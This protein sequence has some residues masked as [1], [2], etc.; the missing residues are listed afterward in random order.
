MGGFKIV[1]QYSN[2]L[3]RKGHHVSVVHPRQLKHM[4]VERTS[5]KGRIKKSAEFLRSLMG[6]PTID[7]QSLD[8]RVSLIFTSS[9]DARHIP[10]G[11][12]IFATGW[13]T[14]AS[15]L[16]C[17]PN[18]GERFYLIQH[19]ETFQADETTIYDTW[20]APLHKVVI[21]KWLLELGARLGCADIEYIPNAINPADYPMLNSVDNRTNS[22]AMMYSPVPF[23]GA[24]DGFQA[25][26]IV[27]QSVPD[28]QVVLFGTSRPSN[29][30]PAWARY[31]RTPPQDFIVK[32]IY[33]R[34]AVF[35]SPS[36][37]EGFALPP[38]EA[39]CCGCALA[40]TDSQGTREYVEPE[41]TGLL[42]APEDPQ[43][44]ADNIIRL[45]KNKDLR[46]KLV[47]AAR[48]KIA[49]I[50]WTE[51]ADKLERFITEHLPSKGL[52]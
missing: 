18:R 4:P 23:K 31:Y 14:V 2:Y 50:T 42:S 22:V 33:N 17:P 7:W 49:R 19:Y 26:E 37:S 28:L 20:R 41:C 35:V 13:H 43:A 25:L 36:L 29:Q 5:L 48:E 1:Y 15:V 44:L 16:A 6:P 51:N 40:V 12:A 3:A 11:D 30:I 32:Q 47:S 34:A 52:V 46:K 24:K 10:E 8:N 39:A 38:A 9:S 27:R 45:L 21:S